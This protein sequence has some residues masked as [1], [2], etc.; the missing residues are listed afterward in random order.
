MR[1]LPSLWA[2]LAAAALLGACHLADD[3]ERE[4]DQAYAAGRYRIA[5]D[6]YRRLADRSASGRL[7]AKAAASA[8]HAGERKEALATLVRLAEEDPSRVAE[9][10]DALI[11]LADDA[12]GPGDVKVIADAALAIRRFAPDR[13]PPR[14]A[15]AALRSGVVTGADAN[16]LIPYALAAAPEAAAV[17]SLLLRYAH[18]FDGALQCDQAV[19]AFRAVLRRGNAPA[20]RPEAAE[21]A[22]QCALRLG[23]EALAQGQGDLAERWYRLGVTTDSASLTSRA[24]ML[25]IAHARRLRGDLAGARAALERAGT[26]DDSLGRAAQSALQ[27]LDSLNTAGEVPRPGQP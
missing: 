19:A 8:A 10:V 1:R 20:L 11:A 14:L 4:A 7:L 3:A 26:P 24:A 15:L 9:A 13:L 23:E 2:A 21:G 16:V 5:L 17:D 22:A 27:L 25:G 12:A 6:G 18:T